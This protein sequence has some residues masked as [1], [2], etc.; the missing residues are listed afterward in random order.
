MIGCYYRRRR[1]LIR[2][3]LSIVNLETYEE[4]LDFLKLIDAIDAAAVDDKNRS[5]F[6]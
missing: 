3:V 6:R 2:F 5:F 1:I 4:E